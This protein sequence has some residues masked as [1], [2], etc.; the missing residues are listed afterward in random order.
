MSYSKFQHP[1]F[2]SVE[3]GFPNDIA[4]IELDRPVDLSNSFVG[5]AQLPRATDEPA[6]NPDCWI[7]GWGR[8]SESNLY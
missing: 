5:L 3:R 2:S 6:G 1:E 4:L 7:A 8:I